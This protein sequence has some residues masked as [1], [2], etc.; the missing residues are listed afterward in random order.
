M[1]AATWLRNGALTDKDCF[2]AGDARDGA[3]QHVGHIN[4][5]RQQ[6]AQGT[7]ALLL[8]KAPGEE[9][10][11]VARITIEKA[12]V[13]MGYASQFPLGYEL[14]GILDERRPAI[15]VADE[16]QHP[17]LAGGG[18]TLDGFLRIPADRFFTQ[19]VFSSLSRRPVDFQVHAIGRSHADGLNGGIGD[20]RAPVGRG[21]LEAKALLG[22]LGT[23]FH[24]VGADNQLGGN[25]ALMKT[26]WNGAIRAA[27]HFTH[28]A[29]ANHPDTDCTCH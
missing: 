4:H 17:S 24:L 11:G 25:P 13:I 12:T 6:V 2:V 10:I 19:D 20:H 28:P 18:G 15:V 9:A 26:I 16:S 23:C 7:Q 3:S 14:L 29:H 21:A 27:V 8:L 22:G 1:G 5:V